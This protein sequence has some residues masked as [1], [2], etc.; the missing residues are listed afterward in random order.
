MKTMAKR[1]KWRRGILIFIIMFAFGSSSSAGEFPIKPIEWLSPVGVGGIA[2]MSMN[3]IA[4]AASKYLGQRVLVVSA[5]GGGTMLASAR[6]A[7]AKPD[8]Y[9]LL[10]ASSSSNG[11]VL[12]LR[13]DVPY[14]NSDFEFIAQ[15]GTLDQGLAV[16]NDSPFK[17]LEDLL[18]FAKKNPHVIKVAT[19]GQ[20]TTPHLF[21]ELLK[22]EV[23]GLQIDMVPFKTASEIRTAFIG[24]HVQ[25]GVCGGG[26]GGPA[27]EWRIVIE[28]GGRFLADAAKRHPKAYPNVPT[29]FER[30]FNVDFT[31]WFGIAGP[32][33]MPK[34]VSQK[35]KDAFY[36]AIT[37]P[38]VIE[39]IEKLG[40]VYEF[41]NSEE[42]TEFVV[43]Y[44]R[45]I[46]RI[47]EEAKIPAS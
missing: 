2:G 13:K 44:E 5:P 37:D 22:L 1:L 8:G 18:E 24:G 10:L 7:R 43:E 34:E 14:R 40:F 20:G 23:P 32:K 42:L 41:R 30:G 15:Y 36:K 27:D 11:I 39:E 29:F 25:A 19:L 26:G 16:R 4:E 12:F 35:L 38:K 33:G 28:S 17:T 46:K 9:T 31:S 6:V 3:V 21:L 45:K 47:V